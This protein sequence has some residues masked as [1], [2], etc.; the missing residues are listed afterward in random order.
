MFQKI[1]VP[2]DGSEKSMEAVEMAATLSQ[3]HDGEIFILS[4]FRHHTIMERSFSM[5][6]S[7]KRLDSLDETLSGYAKEVVEAGKTLALEKGATKVRGFVRGG[8]IAKQI[9]SFAKLNEVDLIV[10]GSQ[11]LG[12]LSGYL[13][14]GI[15]QKV[16]GLAK[17]PV[18]VV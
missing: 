13:L 8:Q 15:S 1:L 10:I 17:C 5:S 3:I 14:G 6:R 11:G 18:L 16:A 9:L 12:D 7:S 4:I 2:V